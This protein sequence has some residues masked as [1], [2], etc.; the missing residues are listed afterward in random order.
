[1]HALGNFVGAKVCI[2]GNRNPTWEGEHME[3]DVKHRKHE[4][5]IEVRD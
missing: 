4:L 5:H 3:I 2:D 1:M